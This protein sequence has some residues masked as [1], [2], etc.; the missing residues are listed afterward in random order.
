MGTRRPSVVFPVGTRAELPEV[1]G[2]HEARIRALERERIPGLHYLAFVN[3]IAG[4]L[5]SDTVQSTISLDPSSGAWGTEAGPETPSDYLDLQQ[6]GGAG[7][8]AL[9]LLKN[10]LYIIDIWLYMT[11]ASGTPPTTPAA[12]S[13]ARCGLTGGNYVIGGLDDVFWTPNLA[14]TQ[15]VA[16]PNR[17]AWLNWPAIYATPPILHWLTAGQNSTHTATLSVTVFVQW[18]AE[19]NDGF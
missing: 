9:A 1:A 7:A 17:R 8:Y 12:N 3:A 19:G 15:Y 13:T 6:Y 5:S 18:K 16:E 4:G 2:N 14:G 10:G 11:L